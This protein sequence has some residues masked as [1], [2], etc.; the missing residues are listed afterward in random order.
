MSRALYQAAEMQRFVSRSA[1]VLT[2][3]TTQRSLHQYLDKRQRWCTTNNAIGTG[4][5]K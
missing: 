4:S 1:G 5:E 3:I 2:L